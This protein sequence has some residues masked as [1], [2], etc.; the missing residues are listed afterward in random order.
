V[1]ETGIC[2]ACEGCWLYGVL[3]V[4]EQPARRGVLIVVGGPQYRIGSHRQFVALARSL[5]QAGI[6]VMRFDYRGMG[7]SE[8]EARDFGSVDADLRAAIDAFTAQVPEVREVVLWGLCDAASAALFYAHQDRRVSGLALANP[9][10]R[11][12]AGAARATLKHYYLSRLVQPGLWKK[13]LNGRFDYRASLRSFMKLCSSLGSK[14]APQTEGQGGAA[15]QGDLPQRMLDGFARFNG[16]TLFL[17]S[18]ADLT[19]REFED[20]ASAP[21]WRRPMRNGRVSRRV[22]AGADHTFSRAA[23]RDQAAALTLEWLRSW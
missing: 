23:W 12:E 4:P 22:L 17:I 5:A 1:N 15:A 7:D 3:S 9:W 6:A 20:M 8:G 10:A 19:A 21:A 13:I 16:N 14:A 18:G 11:T 2:F